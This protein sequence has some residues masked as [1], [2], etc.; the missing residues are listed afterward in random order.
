MF[1]ELAST[2]PTAPTVCAKLAVGGGS[3]GGG[4]GYAERHFHADATAKINAGS[5]S[6]GKP[7]FFIKTTPPPGRAFGRRP[8]FLI[9]ASYRAR[10]STLEERMIGLF[11]SANRLSFMFSV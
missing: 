10:Q 7:K 1:S 2:R 8:F 9:F 6:R 11:S 3:G 5:A 4:E